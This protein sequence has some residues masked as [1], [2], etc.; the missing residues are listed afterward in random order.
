MRAKHSVAMQSR[1]AAVGSIAEAF[2]ARWISKMSAD[3]FVTH[4]SLLMV[5]FLIYGVT[6]SLLSQQ[7]GL[8]AETAQVY[9]QLVWAMMGLHAMLALHLDKA[10]FVF[11]SMAME[12][13]DNG[14]V[15]HGRG[16]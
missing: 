1:T 9:T 7:G 12:L 4:L 2:G 13:R 15:D 6:W 16:A 8:S 11:L 5:W 14:G 10:I 3:Q